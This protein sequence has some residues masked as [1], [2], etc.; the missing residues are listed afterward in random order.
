MNALKSE[1]NDALFSQP[2]YSVLVDI[3]EKYG[4]H[5]QGNDSM[6]FQAAAY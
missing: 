4:W 1:G 5:N 3:L 6:H 2:P